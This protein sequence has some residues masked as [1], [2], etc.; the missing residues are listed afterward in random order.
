MAQRPFPQV[1]NELRYGEVVQELTDKLNELVKAVENTR[2]GGEIVLKL[3]LVPTKSNGAIDIIDT[4]KASIPELPKGS[5]LFFAT[6]EGNLVRNN[7]NQPELTGLRT[8]EVEQR[9]EVK[10][11]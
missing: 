2:K 6:V 8:V 9:G 7:P 11:A 3:K 10:S 5:S 4:I 1:L